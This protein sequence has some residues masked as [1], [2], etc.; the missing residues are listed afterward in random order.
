MPIIVDMLTDDIITDYGDTAL[1]R[2]DIGGWNLARSGLS[3]SPL[4]KRGELFAAIRA[5]LVEK[6]NAEPRL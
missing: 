1:Q 4:A 2:G 5:R 3:D 6:I